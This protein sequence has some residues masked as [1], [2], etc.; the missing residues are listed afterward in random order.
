MP[1]SLTPLQE[2]TI[3][4]ML[5]LPLPHPKIAGAANCHSTCQV[6]RIKANLLEYGTIRAPKVLH[7]GH[8]HKMTE[9]ME[10]VHIFPSLFP[11]G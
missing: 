2:E 5:A 8:N 6:H 10:E 4:G 11:E 1:Y 7:Q 3:R 9:E